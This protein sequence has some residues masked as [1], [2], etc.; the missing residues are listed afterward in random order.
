M[1]LPIRNQS[2]E[3]KIII[4]FGP[5]P[6]CECGK[7]KKCKNRARQKKYYDLHRT[8]ILTGDFFQRIDEDGNEK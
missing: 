8:G 6:Q 4:S 1:P 2:E 3:K 5:K 7:C